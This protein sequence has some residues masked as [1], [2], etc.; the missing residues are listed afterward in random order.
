MTPKTA[1]D[2]AERLLARRRIMLVKDAGRAADLAGFHAAKA[3]IRVQTHRGVQMD[4]AKLARD[5]PR[6]AAKISEGSPVNKTCPGHQT[7]HETLTL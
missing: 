4:F 5:E 2:L 3:L 6:L 1:L 7:S